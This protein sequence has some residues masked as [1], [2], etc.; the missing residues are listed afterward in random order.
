MQQND[1]SWQLVSEHTFLWGFFTGKSLL[2]HL[3]PSSIVRI[4]G[5]LSQ[6][7]D[8]AWAVRLQKMVWKWVNARDGFPAGSRNPMNFEFFAETLPVRGIP[9][10]KPSWCISEPDLRSSQLRVWGL[11]LLEVA[12]ASSSYC[13]APSDNVELWQFLIGQRKTCFA[14]HV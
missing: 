5:L 4:N 11:Q 6:S 9:Q 2:A 10:A 14:N 8:Y 3:C 7:C 13:Q 12:C 1:W